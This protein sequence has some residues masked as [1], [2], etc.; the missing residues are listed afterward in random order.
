[1]LL[2]PCM[3]LQ[4]VSFPV[5]AFCDTTYVTHIKTPTCFGTQ[6]P[7]NKV[8]CT[9]LLLYVLFIVINL[10]KTLVVKIHKVCNNI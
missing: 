9:N 7:S 2:I 8:V 6:V 3:F 4:S 1:M 10:I 5:N